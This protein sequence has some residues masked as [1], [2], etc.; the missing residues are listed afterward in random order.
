MNGRG[1]GFVAGLMVGL[2]LVVIF[3]KIANTDKKIKTEY[4][5]RQ[6]RI[7]G[8]AYKYGFYTMILY[9][10]LMMGLYLCDITIPVDPYVTEF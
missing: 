5:E 6:Q 10:V 8:K 2:V 7:R 1:W 3:Y 4:D 9:H